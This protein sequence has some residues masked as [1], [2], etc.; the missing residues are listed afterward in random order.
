MHELL[1]IRQRMA[2]M[3]AAVGIGLG[4]GEQLVEVG[5][6]GL[7]QV[8]GRIGLATEIRVEQVMAAI[9]DHQ[10]QVLRTIL[11]FVGADEGLVGHDHLLL[12]IYPKI[13]G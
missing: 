3:E 5:E 7:R 9:D 2:A 10:V 6:A 8:A 12:F 11:Q 1:A 4:A 13:G